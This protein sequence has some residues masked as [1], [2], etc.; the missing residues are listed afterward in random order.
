MLLHERVR[1]R[2]WQVAGRAPLDVVGR[3]V[4]RT[5]FTA[6]LAVNAGQAVGRMP[7]PAFTA[8]LAVNAGQAV[9]RMPR[10][11]LRHTRQSQTRPLRAAAD[12]TAH[13]PHRAVA[14][15]DRGMRGL[16]IDDR[17]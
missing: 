14:V 5:A 16:D 11:A 8:R 6:R 4:P 1:A 15:D 12:P 2:L 9:G 13:S 10:P 3:S 7:R 17:M